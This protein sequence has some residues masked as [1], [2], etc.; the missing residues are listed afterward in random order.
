MRRFRIALVCALAL[1]SGCKRLLGSSGA[2]SG[3]QIRHYD[4]GPDGLKSFFT[5]VLDAAKKDDRDRVHDLLAT[6][7]MRDDELTALFGA[8]GPELASRYHSLMATL[9]NR[10]AVELVAQIYDRKYD[11]I[12]VLPIDANAKDLRPDDRAVLDALQ[13]PMPIYSVRLRRA[14][15]DKGLRYDFF[16]YKDGRWLTG[17]QLGK[18]LGK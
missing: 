10:G 2:E 1:F 4:D 17:N 12:D 18:S 5:D 11:T 8:R 16:F 6:L 14:T 13:H 9:V 3:A 7:I 15:D